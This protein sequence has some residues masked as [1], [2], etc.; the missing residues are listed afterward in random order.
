MSSV[1]QE[2]KSVRQK[3]VLTAQKMRFLDVSVGDQDFLVKWAP[4]L[5][6]QHHVNCHHLCGSRCSC[7][8]SLMAL[9]QAYE[10]PTGGH[11]GRGL[12][13]W[14]H[15]RLCSGHVIDAGMYNCLIASHLHVLHICAVISFYCFSEIAYKRQQSW[16]D[17]SN[18]ITVLQ[19]NRCCPPRWHNIGLCYLDHLSRFS[20]NTHWSADVNMETGDFSN[21]SSHIPCQ[22]LEHARRHRKYGTRKDVVVLMSDVKS[23]F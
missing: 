9:T 5:F 21:L 2:I 4:N 6:I 16:P 23:E 20:P 14:Q 19:T 10:N 1:Q 11:V 17:I 7:V 22:G 13:H 18:V 3:W 8:S 12:V 15:I